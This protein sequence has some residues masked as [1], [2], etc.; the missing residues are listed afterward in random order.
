MQ[1][2]QGVFWTDLTLVE[3][4]RQWRV[5]GIPNRHGADIRTVVDRVVALNLDAEWKE[6]KATRWRRVQESIAAI[7]L[8]RDDV[9][10]AI[11]RVNREAT[12]QPLKR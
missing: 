7:R 2:H 6:R 8:W 3:G 11:V 9:R 5:D 12:G 4:G 1:I 10:A